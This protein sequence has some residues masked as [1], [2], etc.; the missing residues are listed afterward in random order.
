MMPLSLSSIGEETMI[1]KIGGSSEV[2]SHLQDMGFVPGGEVKVVS[3]IGGNIIVSV[4]ES[5]VALSKEL[6]SKIFV[7]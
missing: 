6:A 3:E 1:R 4:K 2:R 5:R 7:G